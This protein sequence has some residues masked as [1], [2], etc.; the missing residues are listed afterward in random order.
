VHAAD[1]L[2]QR[3]DA[4][5]RSVFR[6]VSSIALIPAFLDW[7]GVESPAHPGEVCDIDPRDL[8]FSASVINRPPSARFVCG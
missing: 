3:H 7:S 4:A 8:S 2:A 5:R 6:V 1:G